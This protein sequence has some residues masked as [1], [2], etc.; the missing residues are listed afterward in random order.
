MVPDVTLI[1]KDHR[2]LVGEER[3]Q[4]LN[5]IQGIG[6]PDAVGDGENV[7]LTWEEFYFGDRVVRLTF[8]LEAA[9]RIV[10]E[11]RK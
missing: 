9:D 6:L 2:L 5:R 7:G 8:A 1:P 10:S 3:E 4:V 11:K